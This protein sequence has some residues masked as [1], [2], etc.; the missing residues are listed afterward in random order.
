M[1]RETPPFFTNLEIIF[2]NG[3]S[4]N[5]SVATAEKKEPS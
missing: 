2:Y 4:L 5:P 1:Y 3:K